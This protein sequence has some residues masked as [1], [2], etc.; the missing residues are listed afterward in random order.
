MSI[1]ELQARDRAAARLAADVASYALGVPVEEILEARQGG[2]RA[3][4]FARHVAVYL[5]HTGFEMSLARVAIAFGR[6]RSTIAHACHVIEDRRE[7]PQFDLWIGGLETMLQQTP[8]SQWRP[9]S[10]AK[11]S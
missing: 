7:E 3:T 6:D 11:A 5:C 9:P 2:P 10:E 4:A 8:T 1:L